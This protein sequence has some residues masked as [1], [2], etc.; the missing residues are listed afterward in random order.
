MLPSHPAIERIVKKKIRQHWADDRP[1]RGPPF[2]VHQGPIRHAYGRLEPSLKVEKHPFAVRVPSHGS[3]QEVPVDLI[4]EALDIK[5]KHPVM[6]PTSPSGHAQ[7][8]VRRFPWTISIGILVK[9]G[10]QDWF[11]V[12]F[13]NHLGD[14]VGDRWNAKRPGPSR[15]SL[16]YVNATHGWRKVASGAHPIPDPIEVLTQVPFEILDRLPVNPSRPSVRLHLLV[17]FPHIAF[18]NTKWLGFIHAGH[19][20]SGC[21]LDR[22][23]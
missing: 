21:L 8:L 3:H 20:P 16:R 22:A 6:V 2:S 18:R 4:E 12:S 7:C 11:Q 5:V 19:P 23:G 15:I 10:F 17:R 9:S 1:L 13:D 14:S